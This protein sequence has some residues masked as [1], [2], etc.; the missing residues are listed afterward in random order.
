MHD[1]KHT[2]RELVVSKI[3]IYS[4]LFY[5]MEASR[6]MK[7]PCKMHY[8]TLSLIGKTSYFT[9]LPSGVVLFRVDRSRRP[10]IT[11]KRPDD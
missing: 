9:Q 10:S 11:I 7:V 2:S 1:K 3:V 5:L 8:V 4:L 6:E